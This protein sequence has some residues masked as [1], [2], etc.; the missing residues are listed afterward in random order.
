M[1][2]T[3]VCTSGALVCAMP[4]AVSSVGRI[5]FLIKA[6][7]GFVPA[8]HPVRGKLGTKPLSG[9]REIVSG[10][11]YRWAGMYFR[12][13]GNK[14]SCW[15]AVFMRVPAACRTRPHG[16]VSKYPL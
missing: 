7:I 14:E 10:N 8:L 2:L 11:V 9:L 15:R 5:A 1:R 4:R 13:D 12:K 3:I 16:V 6:C